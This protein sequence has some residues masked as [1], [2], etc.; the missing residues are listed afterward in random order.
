MKKIKSWIRKNGVIYNSN[1]LTVT[2]TSWLMMF[3]QIIIFW[4]A[5]EK[6]AFTAVVFEWLFWS[7][8]FSKL[9]E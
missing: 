5:N 8:S 9:E 3:P 6:M 4:E 2:K 7:L 1:V